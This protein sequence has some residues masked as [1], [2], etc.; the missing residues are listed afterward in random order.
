MKKQLA[1]LTV[2][3]TFQ[4]DSKFYKGP[5]IITKVKDGGRLYNYEAQSEADLDPKFRSVGSILHAGLELYQEKGELE[6]IKRG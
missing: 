2:G 3:T 5:H 4:I 6:I 1:K